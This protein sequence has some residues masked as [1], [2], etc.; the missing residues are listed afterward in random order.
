MEEEIQTKEYEI[1]FLTQDEAGKDSVLGLLR[2]EGGEVFMEGPVEKIV[3]AYDIEKHTSA[4]F[5]YFHFRLSPDKLPVLQHDLTTD[6]AVLRFLIVTPPFAKTK[7]R[8]SGRPKAVSSPGSVPAKP[9]PESMP[10]SNEALEKKIEEILQ[11]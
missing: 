8:S 4:Y 5:G 11:Q 6:N 10:L 1:S 9:A 3:L 2:R 7:P